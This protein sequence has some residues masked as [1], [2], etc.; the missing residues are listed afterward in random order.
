MS[1]LKNY[2]KDKVNEFTLLN[3][4]INLITDL[5]KKISI[6]HEDPFNQ[7]KQIFDETGFDVI[8]LTDEIY[9]RILGFCGGGYFTREGVIYYPKKGNFLVKDSPILDF[10][11]EATQAHYKGKQEFYITKKQAKKYL[12]N[13]F[14]LPDQELADFKDKN[15]QNKIEN[16]LATFILGEECKKKYDEFQKF[17][18]GSSEGFSFRMPNK[19]YRDK[20]KNPFV[21]QVWFEKDNQLRFDDCWLTKWENYTYYNRLGYPD[22][23]MRYGTVKGLLS[24][25]SSH[26][27]Q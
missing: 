18:F 15:Y 25:Y 10:P 17:H 20:Q 7:A 11:K 6:I 26:N 23:R 14:K 8:S 13:S 1:N 5:E 4:K 27:K 3:R 19:K 24:E 12:Q 16:E 9:L 22:R 2:L 21:R